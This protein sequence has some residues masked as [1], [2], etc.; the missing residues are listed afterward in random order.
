MQDIPYITMS[1][2]CQHVHCIKNKKGEITEGSESEI[3]N[4]FYVWKVPTH[5]YTN[6]K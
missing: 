3:K 5:C 4:V 2:V 1:F 6:A